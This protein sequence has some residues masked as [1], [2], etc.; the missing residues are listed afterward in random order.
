MNQDKYRQYFANDG[1]EVQAHTLT[2]KEKADLESYNQKVRVIRHEACI[3]FAR[4]AEA[5][6]KFIL[7]R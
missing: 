1:S 4:S 2:P 6:R 7:T 5:A 3:A